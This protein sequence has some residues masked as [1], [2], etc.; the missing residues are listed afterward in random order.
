MGP[1][2]NK[3]APQ[4]DA[5]DPTLFEQ[6]ST[7]STHPHP[8]FGRGGIA[9]PGLTSRG[10]GVVSPIQ[11]QEVR[12]LTP[13]A[14]IYA[15]S[16]TKH[17][18]ASSNIEPVAVSNSD[19]CPGEASRQPRTS[20]PSAA[21]KRYVQHVGQVS[22][23]ANK[24]SFG[25]DAPRPRTMSTPADIHPTRATTVPPPILQSQSRPT[26]PR[27]RT[28]PSA[29]DGDHPMAKP[30]TPPSSRS[31]APAFI[32]H[33]KS[34][35]SNALS[36]AF[37]V[38]FPTFP[39]STPTLPRPEASIPKTIPQPRTPSLHPPKEK[40]PTP[41]ISRL[42]GRGFV[43][44]MVKASS[45]LEAAV[46]GPAIPEVGKPGP[47]KNSP[48]IT[49]RWKREP[50]F[51]S[52][53]QPTTTP[54]SINFPKSW[55]SSA[56]TSSTQRTAAQRKSW[57]TTEPPKFEESER[58]LPASLDQ[59]N[60]SHS[61][62]L[63]ESH[64]TGRSV[65]AVEQEHT[66]VSSQVLGPENTERSTRKAH[67]QPSLSTPSR[68]STPPPASPGGHGL[69]SS[70]TMFSYIKPI[71]TGDDPAT[72][73]SRPHS[74]PTTPHPHVSASGLTSTQDVDELGHR[75][76]VSSVSQQRNGLVGFPAPSG[77]PLVHVRP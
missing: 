6:R 59:Q 37:S 11:D 38:K 58:E 60:T 26:S 66:E 51:S 15:H 62:R 35:I 30:P 25:N 40:D 7:N 20:T 41:S 18:P 77:R 45:A 32:A 68:S 22:T 17:G 24:P 28:P 75:T 8:V 50:S 31:S 27:V 57:T 16:I 73:H 10:Y 55:T 34:T 5:T 36:P 4:L 44:S 65:H 71:K 76:V 43:Q 74:R 42:K 21:L 3:H 46:A 69:G 29:I 14:S 49:S 72:G 1:R 54:I 61:V 13:T 39:V 56:A 19:D 64:H 70:S 52:S 53:S 23:Q 9:M 67:S 33:K 63:V 48:S 47:A 2:L 12:S